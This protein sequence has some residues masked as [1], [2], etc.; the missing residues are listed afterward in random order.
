MPTYYDILGVA[1]TASEEDIRTA[2]KNL[3]KAYHPDVNP[4]PESEEIIKHLNAAYD[5][6]SDPHKRM[7]YDLTL[8]PK[9]QPSAVVDP[10]KAR[11]RKEKKAQEAFAEKK[12]DRSI[13]RMMMIGIFTL[14]LI[15]SGGVYW[16]SKNYIQ[17]APIV[18]LSQ[19]GLEKLPYGLEGSTVVN[20]LYLHHNNLKTLPP[21]IGTLSN[22]MELIAAHNQL[23][24]L[25]PQIGNLKK[26]VSLNVAS[27]RITQ[28]PVEIG[29]MTS[30]TELHLS[31][32]PIQRLPVK[33]LSS[34][35]QLKV[36]DIRGCPVPM[37]DV[38]ALQE[39]L[40]YLRIMQ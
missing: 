22:L 21:E 7:L 37:E 20:I 11:L 10:E 12:R 8:Q 30:L 13:L 18:N 1:S 5:T 35:K 33:A 14:A 3:V 17:P 19:R 34:L 39:E 31:H 6:L 16:L 9:A 24:T 38:V 2:Y 29:Q 15:L 36:L 27:N 32:N 28:L 25:P 26:L 23:T 4:A 40:P